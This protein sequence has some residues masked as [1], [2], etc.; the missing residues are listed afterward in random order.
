MELQRRR[1]YQYPRLQK[2]KKNLIAKYG[3]LTEEDIESSLT[4]FGDET[5]Q[6]QNNQMMVEC[7][8]ASVTKNC[9]Y[10]ISNEE[11]RYTYNGE[12]SAALHYNILIQKGVIDTR[13]TTYEFRISLKNLATYMDTVNSDIKVFNHHVKNTTEGLNLR[14]EVVNDLQMKLFQGYKAASDSNFIDH[15][16]KKKDEYMNGINYI[17]FDVLIQLTLKKCNP[18]GEWRVGSSLCRAGETYCTNS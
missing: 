13:A 17:E 8:L 16:N 15:I 6:V 11:K 3:Y 14:G 5:R 1:R 10:K 18:E 7:M 2:S 12:S 9:F 4:Y